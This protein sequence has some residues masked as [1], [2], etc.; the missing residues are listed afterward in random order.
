MRT[1]ALYK[2]G[3]IERVGKS[4]AP[5]IF[6]VPPIISGMGKATSVKFGRYIQMVLA[7]KSRNS[8]ENGAWAYTG[9]AQI[10]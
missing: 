1:K 5:E 10:F 7:N 3:R 9:T 2:F 4:R 8:G 6:E